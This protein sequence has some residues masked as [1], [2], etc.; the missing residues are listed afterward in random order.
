[1]SSDYC[2]CYCWHFKITGSIFL[3]LLIRE[4][5]DRGVF[6]AERTKLYNASDLRSH[7]SRRYEGNP[8]FFCDLG[9]MFALAQ[10]FSTFFDPWTIFS[11]KYPMDHFPMLAPHEQL[12]ETVLHIGQ[13]TQG[14]VQLIVLSKIIKDLWNSL[15]TT[16][17][18]R[19]TT[20]GPPG[21][22]WESLLQHKSQIALLCE[23]RLW[24]LPP[25]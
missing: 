16:R 15:W 18:S 25:S 5:A 8:I 12:V 17:N 1:M 22:G 20:G 23:P 2:Y 24:W 10:W 4:T 21:P 14:H 3:C 13:W 9:A 19:W 6:R 7:A 11:G